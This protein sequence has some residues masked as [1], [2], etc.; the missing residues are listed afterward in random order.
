M[1]IH[2]LSDLH[3]E[4]SQYKP[5]LAAYS[6]DVVILAGDIWKKDHGVHMARS[7]FASKEVVM[8]LGNHEHY[9]Q[10]IHKNI[11]RIRAAAEEKGIHLL[12]NNE[13]VITVNG[14]K[15][16]LIGC[17]LW[18]DFLLFGNERRS[19][20]IMDAQQSLND[21]RLI[22]NGTWNFSPLDSV[23]LHKAS[24]KFI[25]DRLSVP[26]DGPTIV[27]THHA[28]SYQSVAPRFKDDLLSACFASRLDHL[29]DGEKTELWC[30]GH[31]HDSMDYSINGTRVIANPR[32]YNR[33]GIDG[34]EEN[35]HFN[36]SL[37]IEVSKG[38][39]EIADTPGYEVPEGI[40]P[41]LSGR[42]RDDLIREI[43][44]LKARTYAHSDF[45]LE[46]VDLQAIKPGLR[47][48]AESIVNKH[49]VLIKCI[50]NDLAVMPLATMHIE[51]LIE[52]VIK[53]SRQ[54]VRKP[55][56]RPHAGINAGKID[57]LNSLKMHMDDDLGYYDL[58]EL[59]QDLRAEYWQERLGSTQPVIK[60]ASDPVYKTDYE[61]WRKQQIGRLK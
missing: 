47:W 8:V 26:F 33:S 30:H 49:D 36:S 6:A 44:H 50:P 46:Y 55:R 32:G 9:G 31:T 10:D 48:F 61:E 56:R 39:V 17:T 18:T 51:R 41:T 12:E 37:I 2:L 23:E 16:R 53:R 5:H 35:D 52:E 1:R 29:M 54:T 59:R 21:F 19:E 45:F 20:C 38:K 58:V 3:L 4:F 27:V 57:A 15:I 11:E 43:D 25:E 7:I 42:Q 28:P 13:V 40:E 24:V 60:N 34:A 14:E 22:R